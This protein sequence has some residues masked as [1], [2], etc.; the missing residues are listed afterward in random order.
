ML[1]VVAAVAASTSAAVFLAHLLWRLLGLGHLLG[2]GQEISDVAV[3]VDGVDAVGYGIPAVGLAVQ[4]LGHESVE[5]RGRADDDT[6]VL[7]RGVVGVGV[8]VRQ[9]HV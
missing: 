3:H 4:G 5:N 1:L 9:R 6:D 8:L 2:A 7:Q